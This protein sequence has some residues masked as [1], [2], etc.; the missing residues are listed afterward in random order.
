MLKKNNTIYWTLA[1]KL[2]TYRTIEPL[3]HSIVTTLWQILKLFPIYRWRNED[4]MIHW[5]ESIQV[6]GSRVY[7]ANHHAALPWRSYIKQMEA[8]WTV[9]SCFK[10]LHSITYYT[11]CRCYRITRQPQVLSFRSSVCTHDFY[12]LAIHNL[13]FRVEML[14][15]KKGGLWNRDRTWIRSSTWSQAKVFMKKERWET[16]TLFLCTCC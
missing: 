5:A 3:F 14:E 4:L 10:C 13:P 7:S 9:L 2:Y 6:V 1:L 16:P 11:H 8:P 12:S 15:R